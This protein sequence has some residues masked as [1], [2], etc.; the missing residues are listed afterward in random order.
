MN[1][2]VSL[3][4]QLSLCQQNTLLH[5]YNLT[6]AEEARRQEIPL[7]TEPVLKDIQSIYEVL[8]LQKRDVSVVTTS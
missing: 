4:S 7:P 1:I 2:N 5:F 3:N 6:L 8:P